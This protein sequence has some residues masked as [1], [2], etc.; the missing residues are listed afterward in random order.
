MFSLAGL[1]ANFKAHLPGLINKSRV[2]FFRLRRFWRH[3]GLGVLGWEIRP[4][5]ALASEACS[6]AVPTSAMYLLLRMAE[7]VA[8]RAAYR[9]LAMRRA[10][11]RDKTNAEPKRMRRS[12]KQARAQVSTCRRVR[13]T[14]IVAPCHVTLRRGVDQPPPPPAF[15]APLQNVL[16]ACLFL[17]WMARAFATRW[18][19][20]RS[21]RRPT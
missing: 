11:F 19:R 17:R 2:F 5:E 6:T 15:T 21:A 16:R 20:R 7:R 12:M 14:P 3:V 4:R 10:I 9:G 1:R 18:S 8:R 13:P